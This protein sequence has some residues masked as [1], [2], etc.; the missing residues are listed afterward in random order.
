MK[1]ELDLVLA[2]SDLNQRCTFETRQ[3]QICGNS[4]HVSVYQPPRWLDEIL[5]LD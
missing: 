3:I 5:R 2:Y 4:V 1:V